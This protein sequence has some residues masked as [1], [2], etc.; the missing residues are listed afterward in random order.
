M[1]VRR[2]TLIA[3]L[4]LMLAACRAHA[5]TPATP[6]TSPPASATPEFRTPVPLPQAPSSFELPP[7]AYVRSAANAVPLGFGSFCWGGAC[8]DYV[9]PTTGPDPLIAVKDEVVRAPIS[10]ELSPLT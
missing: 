4:L 1:R 9:G 3:A 2:L 5:G 8:V 10:A 7:E 6:T